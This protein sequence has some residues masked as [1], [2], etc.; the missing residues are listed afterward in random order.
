[1]DIRQFGFFLAEE[2]NLRRVAEKSHATRPALSRRIQALEHALGVLLF[3]GDTRNVSPTPAGR[4][5]ATSARGGLSAVGAGV[6]KLR[7]LADEGAG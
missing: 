7:H 6:C 2:L 4:Q 5:F 1:M 3:K